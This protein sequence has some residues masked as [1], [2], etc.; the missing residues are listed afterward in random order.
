MPEEGAPGTVAA[1]IC[2]F[3]DVFRNSLSVFPHWQTA[4]A[5]VASHADIIQPHPGA[6]LCLLIVASLFPATRRRFTPLFRRRRSPDSVS[7]RRGQD[8]DWLLAGRSS[9]LSRHADI[10]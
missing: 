4:A 10:V 7:S 5:V 2:T 6:L 9:D 1:M 3:N 8:D